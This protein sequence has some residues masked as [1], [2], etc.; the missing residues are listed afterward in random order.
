MASHSGSAKGTKQKHNVG[1]TKYNGIKVN[2]LQKIKLGSIILRQTGYKIKAGPGVRPGKDYTL[3]ANKIGTV[4]Y[5]SKKI[6]KKNN[7][8]VKVT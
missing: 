4:Y 3:F 5:F 7:T 1:K 2:H 6:S 8:Y